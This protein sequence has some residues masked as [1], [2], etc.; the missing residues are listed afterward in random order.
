MNKSWPQQ[1]FAPTLEEDNLIGL[2]PKSLLQPP[3]Q[4]AGTRRY[5]KSQSKPDKL[6]LPPPLP[7]WSSAE[8]RSCNESYFQISP[9]DYCKNRLAP[10][11]FL[12]TVCF[13][14]AWSEI[15]CVFNLPG[16]L[17]GLKCRQQ[18]LFFF[19]LAKTPYHSLRLRKK[20]EE[21]NEQQ[22]GF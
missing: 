16:S 4:P 7:V 21:S 22:N 17:F 10:F 13:I 11:F 15:E 12:C 8:K 6:L 20:T 9:H 18:L 5:H 14:S 3:A 19:F 2:I 1:I